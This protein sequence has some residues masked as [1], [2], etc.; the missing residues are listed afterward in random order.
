[1][2]L[3]RIVSRAHR[4]KDTV[5]NIIKILPIILIALLL[6]TQSLSQN[7]EWSVAAKPDISTE[8][9]GISMLDNGA[10]GWAIGND[11]TIGHI[12]HT[13]DGWKTWDE[14]TDK[15]LKDARFRDVCFINEFNGWIVGKNG[16][17]LRTIDG[18]KS[19]EV[20]AKNLTAADLR[21]IAVIDASHAVACGSYGTIIYT[22]D[23][24]K[25]AIV[26]TINTTNEF[27]GI[28][29][30]DENH[31][32]AVGRKETIFH[33]DD[34]V[35]WKAAS[36]IPDVQGKDFNAVYMVDQHTVWLVGSGEYP[37]LKSILASTSDGG[38]TWT[39]Y[40]PQKAIF[41][42]L[43]AIDFASPIAGVAVGANGTV[44]I[45][46]DAKEWTILP[47]QFGND[48]KAV[49]FVENKIWAAS[50][51]GTIHYSENLGRSW[52]IVPH[53][54]ANFLYKICAIDNRRIIS[55]G[56]NSSIVTTEDEGLNWKS[57]SVVA[58]NDVSKQLWGV[59]FAN[60]EAGW[61]AGSGGFIAKTI[62]GGES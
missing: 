34:G 39:L 12:Y 14:Q 45:T 36:S 35:T 17:I 10:I 54:T 48:S 6:S 13:T 61:V 55:V 50:I 38:N 29:M 16:I 58:D 19:W 9:S 8:I 5:M 22:D 37:N 3:F 11:E 28:D 21:K 60:S 31:G 41:E 43:W 56:Y 26:K 1:M 18:G 59:D 27:M 33:T 20:Q 42:N 57:G 30:Y 23:G 51:F 44:L 24:E 2:E 53:L 62:D 32:I 47:R 15:N 49:A 25:W 52:S 40:Q 7:W 4:T 46:S